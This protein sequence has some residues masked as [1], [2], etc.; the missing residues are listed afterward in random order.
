VGYRANSCPL[1]GFTVVIVAV[2]RSFQEEE[3]EY[4]GM[5]IVRDGSRQWL[6]R[7]LLVGL[8]QLLSAVVK[9]DG[10]GG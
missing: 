6:F 3:S 9:I 7:P 5:T 10:T 2:M 1:A 4:Q 8:G